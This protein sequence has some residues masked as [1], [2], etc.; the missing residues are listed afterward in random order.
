MKKT[1]IAAALSSAVFAPAAFAEVQIYGVLSQGVEHVRATGATGNV[2][3]KDQ[4]EGRIRIVD[5]SSR[6]G[7]KGQEDL[8]NGLKVHWQV[9]QG[10]NLDD[11]GSTARGFANRS[12]FIGL[13]GDFGDVRVG[14]HED[15]Y[16]VGL[17]RVGLDVLSGTTAGNHWDANAI[18]GRMGG[19]R[20]NTLLYTSPKFSGVDFAASYSVDEV[21]SYSGNTR[22]NMSVAGAS[23]NYDMS[24]IKASLGYNRA[25]DRGGVD[26]NSLTG[27][28]AGVSYKFDNTMIGLGYERLSWKNNSSNKRTQDAWTLAATHQIGAVGLQA[29]YSV[30]GKE[31]SNDFSA[32]NTNS[33]QWVLGANY[34]F[35]KRTKIQAYATRI[36]NKENANANFGVNKVSQKLGADPQAIGVALQHAF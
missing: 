6:L 7:F 14:R 24:G 9:E 10:V 4:Y 23:L 18:F 12:S 25:N 29:S 30:R 8:G 32:E 21:R 36:T 22:T 3:E 13:K 15:A 2:A 19:R 26:G 1:L 28:A 27:L 17:N 34:S 33:N 16:R 5:H 31:K 20:D 11:G 35:S